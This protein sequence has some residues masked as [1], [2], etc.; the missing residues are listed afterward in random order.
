[1]VTAFCD[2]VGSP[3]LRMPSPHTN[4]P[5]YPARSGAA[6]TNLSNLAAE[7]R[8]NSLVSAHDMLLHVTCYTCLSSFLYQE[9]TLLL[10][11]DKWPWLKELTPPGFAEGLQ[12]TLD[13]YLKTKPWAER[14]HVAEEVGVAGAVHR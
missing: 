2:L 4:S 5:I 7:R 13:A 3:P 10:W 6:E 14:S 8:T 9:T 1:M 11:L 12:R